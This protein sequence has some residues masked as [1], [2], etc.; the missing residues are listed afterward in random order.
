MS[1]AEAALAEFAGSPAHDAANEAAEILK[2]FLPECH[3]Q[4]DEAGQCLA[5]QPKLAAGLGNTIEQLLAASG[6]SM[7]R[8]MGAGGGYSMRRSTLRNVGLYGARPLASRESQGAGRDRNAAGGGSGATGGADKGDREG[9]A[10]GNRAT[11]VRWI[12][13]DG[14]RAVSPARGRLFPARRR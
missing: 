12:Q 8:G 4:G 13:Y 14:S 1:A 6:L 11:H 3:A 10:A 7:G 2:R 9:S 5:F